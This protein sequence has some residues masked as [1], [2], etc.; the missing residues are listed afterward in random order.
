LVDIMRVR[1]PL[2]LYSIELL[3]LFGLRES[4]SLETSRK[5]PGQVLLI[6]RTITD[7]C[8]L[9]VNGHNPVTVRATII[10]THS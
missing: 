6:R 1:D 9:A 8:R 7:P 5:T 4:D 2:W 3:G 10:L